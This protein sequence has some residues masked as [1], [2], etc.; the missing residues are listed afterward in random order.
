MWPFKNKA[1]DDFERRQRR[2]EMLKTAQLSAQVGNMRN[3][4]ETITRLQ[5]DAP[6]NDV[7][8]EDVVCGMIDTAARTVPKNGLALAIWLIN[9]HRPGEEN[10]RE[11]ATDAAFLLLD[12]IK[13]ADESLTASAAMMCLVIAANA[14]AGSA[15]EKK[16]LRLWDETV[17]NLGETD[18]GIQ[19]AFAAAS[20]AA[21]VGEKNTP[22]KGLALDK[23]EE[24]VM[25]LAKRDKAG[26]FQETNRVIGNYRDFGKDGRAFRKRAIDTMIKVVRLP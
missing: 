9:Q 19:F 3:V 20:N 4:Y 1:R 23:W 15:H 25:K 13:L 18:S 24:L 7:I 2:D 12:R 8:V 10:L 6:I 16:A 5:Q 26:A 22:L 21:L 14:S 17:S 11:R